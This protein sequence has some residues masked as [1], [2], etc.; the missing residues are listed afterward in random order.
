MLGMCSIHWS[1][2]IAASQARPSV[3]DVGFDCAVVNPLA[4]MVGVAYSV[5]LATIDFD[6]G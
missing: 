1:L 6:S 4:S 5:T 3:G 2:V